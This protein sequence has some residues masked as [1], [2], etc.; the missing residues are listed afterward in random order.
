MEARL[1]CQADDGII[2]VQWNLSQHLPRTTGDCIDTTIARSARNKH[3]CSRTATSLSRANSLILWRSSAPTVA[4][5]VGEVANQHHQPRSPDGHSPILPSKNWP[6]LQTKKPNF[7]ARRL[8][9]PPIRSFR[10]SSPPPFLPARSRPSSQ[11]T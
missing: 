11:G 1:V 8:P 9:T 4:V 6:L 10:T 7:L 5:W 2:L 3:S